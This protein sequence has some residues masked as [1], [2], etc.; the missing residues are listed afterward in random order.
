MSEL[1]GSREGVRDEVRSQPVPTQAPP[2]TCGLGAAPAIAAP[3]VGPGVANILSLQRSAGNQAVARYLAAQGSGAPLGATRPAPGAESLTASPGGVLLRDNGDTA[4]GA[5]A[6]A[7]NPLALAAQRNAQLIRNRANLRL[8]SLGSFNS[9]VDTAF[10]AYEP[11]RDRLV[12][13]YRNAFRDH[14]RVLAAGRAAAESQNFYTG[15]VIGAAASVVVAAG[16]AIALPAVAAAP[17]FSGV[18]WASTA[19]QAVASSAGGSAVGSA[20]STDTSGYD[21]RGSEDDEELA[22]LRELNTLER[23]ARRMGTL[24]VN[25]GI[26]ASNAEYAVSQIDALIRHGEADMDLNETLTLVSELMNQEH[27]VEA[28]DRV[29]ANERAG[30][31]R[32]QA[33]AGAWEVPAESRVEQDIWIAWISRVTDGDIL[34]RDA[35]ENHLLAIGVLGANGRLGVDFGSWTS[36]DD[37]QAAITAAQR[38][39]QELEDARSA[40]PSTR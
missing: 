22:A 25:F 28:T 9:T 39:R 15:I 31:E 5:N 8:G 4:G 32:L 14:E 13:N 6:I 30:F 12:R 26:F 20:V 40:Q 10:R 24:G 34:D 18:W 27:D 29:L 21:A 1:A 38:R 11:K 33:A 2:S 37:E 16:V 7:E 17:V 23:R 3:G 35:I 36:G 19:G